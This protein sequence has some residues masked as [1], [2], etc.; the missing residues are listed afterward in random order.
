M[1]LLQIKMFL[2]AGLVD[3]NVLIGVGLAMMIMF[4]NPLRGQG[5][6]GL[7]GGKLC[8]VGSD[9]FASRSMNR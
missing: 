2:L 5:A 7:G 8:T 4:A 9:R 6:R 3:A 1:A